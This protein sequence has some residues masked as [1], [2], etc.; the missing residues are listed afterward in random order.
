MLI[1]RILLEFNK[2]GKFWLPLRIT[3]GVVREYSPFDKNVMTPNMH[4]IQSFDSVESFLFTRKLDK[5]ESF[6]VNIG[7]SV[8]D[9]T[10]PEMLKS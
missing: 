3:S 4:S 10:Y 7:S 8:A 5:T 1:T 2:R 6:I 9:I